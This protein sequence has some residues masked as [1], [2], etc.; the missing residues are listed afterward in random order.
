[1][2]AADRL[3]Q[4]LEA[5][6]ANI[7]SDGRPIIGLDSRDLLEMTLESDEKAIFIPGSYMDSAL[8]TF[9]SLFRF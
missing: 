6:G 3:S 7:H 9:R 5:I 1:M 4:K 2:E 8:L